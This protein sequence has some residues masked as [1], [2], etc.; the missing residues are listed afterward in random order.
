MLL[1][2]GKLELKDF[3]IEEEA[4]GV[5]KPI[6]KPFSA[7]VTNG[8]MDIRLYWA[9]KGTT[10]IPERGVYGPLISAI[11]LHNP[12]RFNTNS[13]LLSALILFHFAGTLDFTT[14]FLKVVSIEIPC[15]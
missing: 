6:V 10:E 1:L 4:G 8:T 5:G 9:G 14:I 13:R 11:S 7:V 3:N 2:Q 12:G 15:I